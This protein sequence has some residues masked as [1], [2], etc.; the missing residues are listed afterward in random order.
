MNN[1]KQF[2]ICQSLSWKFTLLFLCIYILSSKHILHL[3]KLHI[4]SYQRTCFLIL[5][6]FKEDFPL[7]I[8]CMWESCSFGIEY[9]CLSCCSVWETLQILLHLNTRNKIC[10][11]YLLFLCPLNM[12]GIYLLVAAMESIALSNVV[13]NAILCGIYDGKKIAV[14]RFSMSVAFIFTAYIIVGYFWKIN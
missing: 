12:H 2:D 6:V 14:V 1:L 3:F 13:I 11:C 4:A 9:F 10:S 8:F 5:H 7:Y